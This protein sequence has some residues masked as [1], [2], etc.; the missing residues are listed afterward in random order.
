MNRIVASYWDRFSGGYAGL[1]NATFWRRHRSRLVA[2]VSGRVLE[3]CCGGGHLVVEMLE[4]GCD[5]YGID[6]SANMVVRARAELAKSGFDPARITQADVTKLPFADGEFEVVVSTGA[7]G[8]FPPDVQRAALAEMTRVA[9]QEIRLLEP[10]EKHPGLY[11]GRILA[12]MF[13]GMR[14]IA[15]EALGTCGDVEVEWDCLGGAF[16]AVRCS[17]TSRTGSTDQ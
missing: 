9:S 7:L 8:L 4:H 17:K 12:W 6:L 3:V 5:A 15:R 13:D 1:G 2:D 11:V 10:V 16:S 14:P